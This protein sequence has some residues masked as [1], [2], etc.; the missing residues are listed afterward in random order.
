MA[1]NTRDIPW[2]GSAPASGTI[3]LWRATNT[4]SASQHM[5]GIKGSSGRWVGTI[6]LL[7]QLGVISNLEAALNH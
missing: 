3:D 2:G 6:P 1:A 5:S 4:L 7:T